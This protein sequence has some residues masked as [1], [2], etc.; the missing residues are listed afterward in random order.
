MIEALSYFTMVA[1]L[2]D[3]IQIMSIYMYF[4]CQ[5]SFS[6]GLID[7]SMRLM[8]CDRQVLTVDTGKYVQGLFLSCILLPAAS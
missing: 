5:F 8:F 6:C 2:K 1:A 7:K 3:L 4:T